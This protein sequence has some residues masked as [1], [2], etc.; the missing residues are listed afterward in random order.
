MKPG[1]LATVLILKNHRGRPPA[2]G[3]VGRAQ[4]PGLDHIPFKG[5]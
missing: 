2:T 1:L 4:P 3:A 5:G